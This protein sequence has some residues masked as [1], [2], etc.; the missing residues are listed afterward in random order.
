MRQVKR[1]RS[2]LYKTRFQAKYDERAS[3]PRAVE[4]MPILSGQISL[5]S[6]FDELKGAMS[7]VLVIAY[8]LTAFGERQV[9][10]RIYIRS[11]RNLGSNLYNASCRMDSRHRM[12]S[13]QG[14]GLSGY[15]Y[16]AGHLYV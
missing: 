2:R 5:E 7:L 4:V 15:S 10:H 14:R 8:E 9:S 12:G 3:G 1:T 11:D 6:H 16:D 13:I